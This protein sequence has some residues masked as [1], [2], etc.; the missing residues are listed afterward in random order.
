VVLN[1][2][3]AGDS[4]IHEYCQQEKIPV[5]LTI[6]LDTEIA[7]LYSKGITLVNGLPEWRDSFTR[8]F[9]QIEEI[10]R[11]RNRDTER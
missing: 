8:L 3:G 2:A 1:R 11:E 4:Q 10:V 6:P 7:R 9:D 5:L